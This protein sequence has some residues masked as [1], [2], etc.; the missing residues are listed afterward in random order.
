MSLRCTPTTYQVT[1]TSG[2]RWLDRDADFELARALWPAEQPLS[3]H[4]WEEAHDAGYRYCGVIEG[5]RLVAMAAEWR[6][7]E[8]AWEAAAVRTLDDYRRRGHGKR[9]VAFVTAHIL[10]SGRVATC[11][12]ASDNLAMIRTAL[13]V[14]YVSQ[15][16]KG[17]S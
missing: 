15:E 9:V 12:T 1:D 3:R 2:V 7:S 11:H 8:E 16:E 10:T 14:G 5:G 4:D 17:N 13:S 6:Y